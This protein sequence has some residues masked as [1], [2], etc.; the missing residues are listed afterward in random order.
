MGS[1]SFTN[2]GKV[3]KLQKQ[4]KISEIENIVLSMGPNFICHEV[5][6]ADQVHMLC[7]WTQ[8]DDHGTIYDLTNN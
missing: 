6:G 1:L 2:E 4:V 8:T 5:V 3:K 7:I